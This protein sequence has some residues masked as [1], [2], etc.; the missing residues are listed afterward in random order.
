[1]F[2]STGRMCYKDHDELDRNDYT[3]SEER[4]LSG[5]SVS[6]TRYADGTSTHHFGGPC[7]SANY[8]ENGEEC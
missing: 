2:R 6:V 1:M 4:T 3:V 8:D 5:S 7:G